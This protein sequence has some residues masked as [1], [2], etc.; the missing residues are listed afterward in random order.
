[1]KN[2]GYLSVFWWHDGLDRVEVFNNMTK[3]FT[4]QAEI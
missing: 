2:V 1:V 4:V 3:E